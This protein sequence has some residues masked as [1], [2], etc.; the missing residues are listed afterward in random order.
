MKLV[1]DKTKISF[2]LHE[3]GKE[4]IIFDD[5]IV[6]LRLTA[7]SLAGGR[8]RPG[9]V[10]G[11]GGGCE[12]PLVQYF[13][14]SRR[15]YGM[16]QSSA[17][18]HSKIIDESLL[19]SY[20]SVDKEAF[21]PDEAVTLKIGHL[22]DVDGSVF[23]HNRSDD[24]Q[25]FDC[26][27]LW[28]SQAVFAKDPVKEIKNDW[29][30][31]MLW[32]YDDGLIGGMIPVTTE[33]VFSKMCGAKGTLSIIA[34][35]AS[36]EVGTQTYP[37]VL[38]SFADSVDGVIRN[39]F[40]SYS[41]INPNL[42]DRVK[43]QIGPPFDKLGWCSWNAFGQ[44]CTEENILSAVKAL[45]QKNIPVKYIIIDDCWQ[46]TI[47][48]DSQSHA[49]GLSDAKLVSMDC[50]KKKFP[51]GMA[52]IIAQCKRLG[53]ES[54]GLWHAMNGYW[55]GIDPDGS[56]FREHP[57]WFMTIEDGCVIPRPGTEFF[58]KWYELMRQWGADFVKVDNQGFHR[59]QMTYKKSFCE[60]MT[61]LQ[62]DLRDAA[63]AA[64]MRVIYCMATHPENIFNAMPQQLLRVTNDF[65]PNDV[66]GTRKHVVNNFYNSAWLGNLFWPDYDMFQTMDSN[67]VALAHSLAISA[68]PIYTTDE[69]DRINSE[70]IRKL[71][72]PDGS[73]TRYDVPAR[74]LESRFFDDP[75]AEDAIMVV[76]AQ[77]KSAITLGLF[78]MSCSGRAVHGHITLKEI[79]L[80]EENYLVYSDTG[81][82]AAKIVS[83]GGCIE[84]FLKSLR[85]DLITLAPVRS[86]FAVIG[87]IDYFAAP[88]MVLE[89]I[90]T[91][92]GYQIK[93]ASAG[94]LLYYSDKVGIN[95]I[96]VDK[97]CVIR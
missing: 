55:Q 23:F 40:D 46:D 88:A 1:Y 80:C 29:G 28:W 10:I 14:G 97:K 75:F 43:G 69:P 35:T 7:V 16:N 51:S 68:S 5:L 58:K 62:K 11:K 65:I 31:L 19:I 3:Q 66:Y 82:F 33:K 47:R 18:L 83:K 86:G 38:I 41:Q 57:E 64:S 84:Y 89:I 6:R 37:L 78:N 44:N 60:Y 21:S 50:S 56:L 71:V 32:K 92:T 52:S 74:V 79:G 94:R 15:V 30:M 63:M 34:S 95:T 2:V 22:P 61:D 91:G 76:M 72:L 12:Y 9:G 96:E 20:E 39:L 42:P 8:I 24:F 54:V 26:E 27:G 90:E 59:R 17:S 45:S 81:A 70:L 85:S 36:C 48:R 49:E 4:R 25:N 77:A 87:L 13:M 53:I 67:A 73:I 93:L